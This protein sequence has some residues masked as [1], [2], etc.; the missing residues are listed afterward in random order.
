MLRH[1]VTRLPVMMTRAARVCGRTLSFEAAVRA[2][3]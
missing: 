1:L 3:L 2:A